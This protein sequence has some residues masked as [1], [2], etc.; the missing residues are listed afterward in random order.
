MRAP[1]S[2]ASP[3]VMG[4]DGS[5]LASTL[6]R[7]A[8]SPN[9]AGEIDPEA[10]YSRIADRLSDLLGARVES[11]DVDR[12]LVREVY[13]LYVDEG[14]G[15]RLPARALSEGT[16]RF[17]ALCVILEDT[18]SHELI[19]MEEPENGIHPANLPAMIQLVRDLAVDPAYAP[20]D[21]NPLRQVIINTH[22]PGVVQLC[23]EGDLVLAGTPSRERGLVLYG[24]EDNWRVAA[25]APSFSRLDALP[26]LTPP[27]GVQ[28]ELPIDLQTS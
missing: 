25:G 19:C 9:P 27:K 14:G 17:L 23:E 28:F 15:R 1:D 8:H 11:I 16:L 4:A 26:Y 21:D 5:H 12:D 22:S 20:D 18:S 7:I 10:V 24:Y 2:F 13:T 6:W 3:Q